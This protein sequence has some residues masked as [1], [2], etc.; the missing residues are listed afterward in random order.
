MKKKLFLACIIFVPFLTS[1]QSAIINSWVDPNPDNQNIA[2]HKVVVAALIYDQGVRRI[3]E[4]YVVS[5]YPGTATQSY[6]LMGDS[7]VTD[8]AGE[9]QKLKSQ[10]FDGIVIMKHT[11]ENDQQQYIPGRAPVSYTTWGGYWGY[12]GGP[13]WVNHYNPGTPGHT[14]N[15]YT[16][17]V[18][19]NVYSLNTNTLIYSANTSTTRPGGTVPLFEDVSNAIHAQL[20]SVGIIQ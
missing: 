1:A 17:F 2:I 11:G 13:H 5:L 18:Q 8:E 16:W 9:S 12:W 20:S 4:D 6:L 15:N 10:G 7:L 3:V 19:V 14:I